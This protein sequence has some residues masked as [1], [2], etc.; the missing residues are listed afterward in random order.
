VWEKIEP[1][2][3]RAATQLT[4]GN[5]VR[6]AVRVGQTA[7]PFGPV[8]VAGSAEWAFDRARLEELKALSARSGGRERL[9]LADVWRAPR[10]AM[11][12]SVQGWLLSA[13]LCCLLLDAALTRLGYSLLPAIARKRGAESEL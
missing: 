8:T 9:D 6:G 13:W 7:L 10:A 4:P 5:F 2:R 11:W 1:G 3:F 12:R